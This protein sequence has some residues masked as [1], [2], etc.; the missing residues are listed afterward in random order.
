MPSN[1][2]P[3]STIVGWAIASRAVTSTLVWKISPPRSRSGVLTRRSATCD[4]DSRVLGDCPN[5]SVAASRMKS[6]STPV[7]A[8]R[9]QMT[10]PQCRPSRSR[11]RA[12]D[13]CSSGSSSVGVPMVL[14]G[15]A[16]RDT[17]AKHWGQTRSARGARLW[18]AATRFPHRRRGYRAGMAQTQETRGIA[19]LMADT[20]TLTER[21]VKLEIER[22]RAAFQRAAGRAATGAGLLAAGARV[23]A[24]RR[25]HRHG[26]RGARPGNGDARLGR[27]ADRRRRRRGAGGA[28]DSARVGP[29]AVGDRDR[30]GE[31]LEPIKED[32]RWLA[33][34]SKPTSNGTSK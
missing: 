9:S 33:H 6:T 3:S 17:D 11:C 25:G 28:A 13:S 34:E 1:Q 5:W 27:R 20:R 22:A 4:E 23:R 7:M 21:L 24:D 19:D 18:R 12:S 10:T 31:V 16:R 15:I 2:P 30:P 8:Q 29:G 32:A 14:P 26:R